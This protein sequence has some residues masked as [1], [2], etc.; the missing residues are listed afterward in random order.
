MEKKTIHPVLNGNMAEPIE[1]DTDSPNQERATSK[2]DLELEKES[3]ERH[4]KKKPQRKPG[5]K[6]KK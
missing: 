4:N 5:G 1:W 3:I 6:G 2:N